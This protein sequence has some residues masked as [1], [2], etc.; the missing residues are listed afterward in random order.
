VKYK[1][2]LFLLCFKLAAADENVTELIA[3]QHRPASEI[4]PLLAPL[5]ENTDRVVDNN[6]S[7]IVKTTPGRLENIKQLV[8]RLDT[9]AISLNITVLQNSFKTAA[10]LNAE[11]GA[12]AAIQMHGMNADTREL[13][14]LENTRS[15]RT[16]SGHPAYITTGKIKQP[17]NAGAYGFMSGANPTPEINSGFMATPQ[18]VGKEVII[19]IEPW[20][21]HFQQGNNIESQTAGARINAKLGEWVEVAGNGNI[22]S[23]QQVTKNNARILLKIDRLE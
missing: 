21:E 5:I 14:N 4:I 1:F 22:P 17:Q 7:L 18:V 23:N 2:W 3:L 20:S 11:S 13:S 16:T 15:I 10:E 9:V 19:D 12:A 6:D 8:T